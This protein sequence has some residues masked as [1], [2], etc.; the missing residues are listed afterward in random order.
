MY[1]LKERLDRI[2]EE[3]LQEFS[4]AIWDRAALERPA[5]T[6]GDAIALRDI[7]NSARSSLVS[8]V[9]SEALR[10][11]AFPAAEVALFGIVVLS[12]PVALLSVCDWKR[13]R[14]K[15]VEERG[16]ID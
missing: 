11:S 10:C 6:W 1:A 7:D 16:C 5:T 2:L 4:A 8:R 14:R 13:R 15:R 12:G 3:W 9:K